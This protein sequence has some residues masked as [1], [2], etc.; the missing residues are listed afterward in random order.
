MC[1]DRKAGREY[2]IEYGSLVVE[3]AV[4]LHLNVQLRHPY[5]HVV[6]RGQRAMQ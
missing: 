4:V 2:R 5:L 6:A 1:F 3:G